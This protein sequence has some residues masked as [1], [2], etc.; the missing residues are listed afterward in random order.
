MAPDSRVLVPA[1][2]HAHPVGV[3]IASFAFRHMRRPAR[4]DLWLN[5]LKPRRTNENCNGI[6]LRLAASSNTG[7]A[8]R[9]LIQAQT[10]REIEF[11]V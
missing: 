7:A 11:G 6:G 3:D 1:P 4:P 10:A 8:R 2:R 5:F 9:I